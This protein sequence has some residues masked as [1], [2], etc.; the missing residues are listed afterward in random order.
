MDLKRAKAIGKL[1]LLFGTP[2]A[3]IFGLF[4]CG[5][6]CGH[7]QRNT[8]T[9]F[10]HDVLGLDVEVVA[11]DTKAGEQKPA[12]KPS[13]TS[14]TTP[15]PKPEPKPEAT[16]EP[17]PKPTPEPVPAPTPTPSTDTTPPTVE[18]QPTVTP[19]S[20]P[21]SKADPLEGELA[22]LHH[23]P[24]KVRVEVLVHDDLVAQQPAWIDYVQRTVARAS[25]IWQT[26]FGIELELVG[27]RRWADVDEDASAV[28][29]LEGIEAEPREG[30]DI[31][32][33]FSQ[34]AF[35]DRVASQ[36]PLADANAY[37]GTSAV[38]Y[39]TPGHHDAHLRTLLYEVARL[40]SARAIEAPT[41]PAYMSGSWMSY[42]PS[43][44]SDAFW[45]D[46]VNRARVLEH[47]MKPFAP[48]TD[49][50]EHEE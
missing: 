13:T 26:Q 25:Q 48:A 42:A 12:D 10:E 8:I 29:L 19:P 33:G 28:E 17:E 30:V 39:A 11:A 23:T 36:A 18:P 38:V 15:T 1:A 7:Q 40:F 50:E 21:E 45:I 37:N 34:R 14:S 27:V 46:A 5:V 2:L 20:V 6:Y 9:S 32:L 47:K 49:E 4:S 31:V 24:T 3:V 35:D 41:D 43:K 22:R 44:E 16:P